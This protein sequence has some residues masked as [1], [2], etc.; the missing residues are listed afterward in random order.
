MIADDADGLIK[1]VQTEQDPE[2]RSAAIEM[3]AITDERKAGQYL[4]SIYPDVSN[5]E[6]RTI[7]QAMMIMDDARG[8]IGMLKTETDPE[9][10]REMMQMLTIIDSEEANEYLF[11]LLEKN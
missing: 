2:M 8:L 1:V 10:R 9:L 4:V 7:I 3:L 11:E 5:D 6:K